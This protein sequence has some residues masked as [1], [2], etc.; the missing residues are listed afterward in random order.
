MP[1]EPR[2]EEYP[3]PPI[4]VIAFDATALASAAYARRRH[5]RFRTRGEKQAREATGSYA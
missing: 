5:A 2:Y 4:A 1:E 3:R